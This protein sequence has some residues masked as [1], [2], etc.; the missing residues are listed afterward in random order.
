MKLAGKEIKAAV[1]NV[2]DTFIYVWLQFCPEI[3]LY[4]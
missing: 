4:Q 3:I 1:E 2:Q